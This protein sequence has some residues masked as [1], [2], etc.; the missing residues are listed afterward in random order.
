MTS[1]KSRILRIAGI[2]G[3]T[4]TERKHTAAGLA[5]QY[6]RHNT[7]VMVAPVKPIEKGAQPIECPRCHNNSM[8]AEVSTYGRVQYCPICRMPIPLPKA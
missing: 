4:R 3:T 5:Q 7:P 6:M 1:E 2:S 8:I